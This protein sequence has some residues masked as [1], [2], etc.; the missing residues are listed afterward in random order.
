MLSLTS[1]KK[2]DHGG[3][4]LCCSNKMSCLEPGLV[5]LFLVESKAFAC[6]EPSLQFLPKDEGIS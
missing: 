2:L 4:S 6:N 1:L 3:Y 5:C